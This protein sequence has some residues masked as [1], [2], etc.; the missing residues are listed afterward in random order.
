MEMLEKQIVMG[1][2]ATAVGIIGAVSYNWATWTT[3]TLISVD[4]RTEVMAAQIEFIKLGMER[5][6]GNVEKPN[7][8]ANFKAAA[9]D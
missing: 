9:K 2:A 8:S 1:V 6:Y 4:K 5:T 3:E 7:E